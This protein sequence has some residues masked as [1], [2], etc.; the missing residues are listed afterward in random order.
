MALCHLY[1][2]LSS[3][4]SYVP[5]TALCHLNGP[6]PPQRP[7]IPSMTLCPST[8]L[9]PLYCPL[10]PLRPF[11]PVRPSVSPTA[12]C[13]LFGPLSFLQPSVPS[14]ALCPL[15]GPLKQHK[16]KDHSC[17]V[18]CFTTRFLSKPQGLL[19]SISYKRYSR[20]SLMRNTCDNREIAIIALA[21]NSDDRDDHI[22]QEAIIVFC[23][24][25]KTP[26]RINPIEHPFGT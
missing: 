25:L 17:F 19:H 3:L 5:S 16:R 1:G 4:W 18:K 11:S 20:L 9:C 2:H 22:Q 7:S 15:Y 6:L 21:K 24:I 8:A 10:S 14:T 23:E 12:L 26:F 13:P